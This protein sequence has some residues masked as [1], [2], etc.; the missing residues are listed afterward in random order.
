[1]ASTTV[2]LTDRPVVIGIFFQMFCHIDNGLAFDGGQLVIM[3]LE[4]LLADRCAQL[5]FEV[6]TVSCMAVETLFAL[7][8]SQMLDRKLWKF[9][10]HGVVAIKAKIGLRLLVQITMIR[11]VRRVAVFAGFGGDRVVFKAGALQPLERFLVA[12]QT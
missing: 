7:L 3:A 9:L 8:Q 12:P 2:L 4:A 5:T 10:F 11:T 6:G 1:M